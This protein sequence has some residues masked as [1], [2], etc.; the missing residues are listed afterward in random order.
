MCF[1]VNELRKFAWFAQ[2]GAKVQKTIHLRRPLPLKK[3]GAWQMGVAQGEIKK[4]RATKFP[5]HV[6]NG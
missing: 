5:S 2:F 1:F 3:G 4:K 6:D